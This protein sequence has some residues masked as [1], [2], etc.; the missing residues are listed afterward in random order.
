MQKKHLLIL[1][2]TLFIVMTGYG[3]TL[4]ILPFYI[5]RLAL[6]EG[7]SASEA[8]FQV[9]AL[10]GVFA[11]MQFFFAPIW[12]RL[13]DQFGRRPLFLLG[14]GG[15][16]IFMIFFGMGTNLK[17]LYAARIL[18]GIF[19]AAVLPGPMPLCPMLL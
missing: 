6:T 7:A 14:L 5:E 18:G 19:S 4:P 10:T 16:A 1:L 12:G 13:S 8:V 17:M 9:G 11:L 3:L 15:Y 2:L